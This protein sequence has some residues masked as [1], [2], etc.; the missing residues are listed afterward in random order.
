[1]RLPGILKRLRRQ[2]SDVKPRSADNGEPQWSPLVRQ[3]ITTL[4]QGAA[5]GALSG[6]FI[7]SVAKLVR[8][9]MRKR[10]EVQGEKRETFWRWQGHEQ[11]RL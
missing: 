8:D 4:K 5:A 10:R 9:A 3:A 11:K 1:M 6:A 2:N 7:V